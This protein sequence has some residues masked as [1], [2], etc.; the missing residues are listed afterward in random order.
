MS[1]PVELFIGWTSAAKPSARKMGVASCQRGPRRMSITHTRP[2]SSNVTSGA[3]TR[4][5]MR[6]VVL[7]VRRY[8]S[9]SSFTR[10]STGTTTWFSG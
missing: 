3:H 5:I 6:I 2:T 4:R 9:G 1:Q 10:V 7:Y 8:T